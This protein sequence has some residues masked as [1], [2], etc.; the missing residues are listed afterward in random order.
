MIEIRFYMDTGAHRAHVTL[1]FAGVARLPSGIKNVGRPCARERS[2]KAAMNL[3][4]A[5]LRGGKVV[6]IPGERAGFIWEFL[7][8]SLVVSPPRGD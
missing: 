4:C 6:P 2:F 1:Y 3:S 8:I 5:G 7:G